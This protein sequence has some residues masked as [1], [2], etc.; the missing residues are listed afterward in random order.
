MQ[1][2]YDKKVVS[3]NGK[4]WN[5]MEKNGKNCSPL[6]PLPVNRLNDNSVQ[7]WPLVPVTIPTYR[8]GLKLFIFT[9]RESQLFKQVWGIK[10]KWPSLHSEQQK[11][12]KILCE[13]MGPPP[14]APRMALLQHWTLQC[15]YYGPFCR[16]CILHSPSLRGSWP[17]LIIFLDSSLNNEQY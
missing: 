11:Y 4:K 2:L 12:T 9:R 3:E 17:N 8:N 15:P 6:T 5:G 13:H 14:W 10:S 16:L 7:R 1:L